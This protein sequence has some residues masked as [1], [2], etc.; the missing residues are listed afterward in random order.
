MFF[1]FKEPALNT[2]IQR[3]IQVFG[4]MISKNEEEALFIL[5][6]REVGPSGDHKNTLKCVLH[7]CK[8]V[9]KVALLKHL[10]EEVITKSLQ[11]K[12]DI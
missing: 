3:Q 6:F 5:L 1:F 12:K 8:A 4:L 9:Y 7:I 10:W 11:N 2:N